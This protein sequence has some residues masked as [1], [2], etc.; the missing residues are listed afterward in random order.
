MATLQLASLLYATGMSKC[1]GR[2]AAEE[3]HCRRLSLHAAIG[4]ACIRSAAGPSKPRAGQHC[5]MR[6][7]DDCG[8]DHKAC[9]AL[10][11]PGLPSPPRYI[12]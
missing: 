2:T 8:I 6:F 7:L 10:S 11:Q 5:M 3:T 1:R 4:P 9:V 12:Q